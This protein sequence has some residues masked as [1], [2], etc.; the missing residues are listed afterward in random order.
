[1]KLTYI[2]FEK[3]MQANSRTNVA[4]FWESVR[5]LNLPCKDPH[6]QIDLDEMLTVE[7]PVGAMYL[8]CN[9]L[10]VGTYQ[11]RMRDSTNKEQTRTYQ[12]MDARGQVYVQGREFTAQ[13]DHMTFNEEKD[14][15]IFIG[16]GDNMAVLSKSVVKGQQPEIIRRQEDYLLP[17]HRP[18]GCL[19][20][21][22]V[23]WLTTIGELSLA[24]APRAP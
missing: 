1:M 14:Q 8:R 2:R 11:R 18:S 17:L 22:L 13:C 7:L 4:S 3:Q 21:W 16:E 10:K 20:S 9:V 15:V 12:E 23:R 19:Q 6:R 24:S 5:V